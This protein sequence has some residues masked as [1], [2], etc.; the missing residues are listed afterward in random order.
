[1]DVELL[2]KVANSIVKMVQVNSFGEEVRVI[3]ANS[4][5]RVEV[6]K[7]SKL[8]K[9]DPFLDSDGLLRAGVR[10]EKSRLSHSELILWFFQNKATY[11]K[12]SYDCAMRML[13]MVEEE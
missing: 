4:D 10:L 8:Y 3:C 1:M 9:L 2:E 11:Q 7:S 6:N 5:S 13:P 12:H